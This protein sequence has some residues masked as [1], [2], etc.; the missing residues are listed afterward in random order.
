MFHPDPLLTTKGG[1]SQSQMETGVPGFADHEDP[2]SKD[3]PHTVRDT[4]RWPAGI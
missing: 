3:S 4:A 1:E 2:T